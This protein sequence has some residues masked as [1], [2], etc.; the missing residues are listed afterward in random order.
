MKKYGIWLLFLMITGTVW[1]E[2]GKAIEPRTDAVAWWN[3]TDVKDEVGTDSMLKVV[4]NVQLNIPLA[5]TEVDASHARSGDGKVAI[6]QDGAYLNAEQGV[7][8]ELS[9]ETREMSFY[10]RVKLPEDLTNCPIFS[11]RGKD[12]EFA[13]NL[14][15][16]RDYIGFEMDT[17]QNKNRLALKAPFSDMRNPEKALTEWHDIIVRVN[18]AKVELYVDGRCYDEDFILGD[19]VRNHMPTLI[20][21]QVTNCDKVEGG[22]IDARFHGI[23]DTVA[24]WHRALTETEIRELSGGDD[25]D[26][27]NR[28]ELRDGEC[29]QYWTPPNNYFVGDTFPFTHNGVFHACF[30]VDKNHHGAK[31]GFGAHQWIQATSTDLKNWTFQPYLVPIEYQKEG[32]ICTGSLFFH[33]GT[34]Y[35]FYANRWS[36]GFSENVTDF[37]D[38]G[39]LTYSE[40]QDGIHFTKTLKPQFAQTPGY[41]NGT[42]DPIVFKSEKDGRFHMYATDHYR[43]KGCWLHASSAD[44]KTWQLEDPVYTFRAKAPECPDWFEWGG[45]YYVIANHY[46]GFYRVSDSPTGPWDLPL[47]P[48][49]LMLGDCRVPKTTAWKDGRRIITGFVSFG[50]YAG[51]L[52]FH[53]LIRHEDGSLGEKFVPEMIPETDAP[54]VE[55]KPFFATEKTWANVPGNCRITVELAFDPAR[56][57]AILDWSLQ[58]AENA[59][60][61]VSPTDRAVYLG[62]FKLEHVNFKTG[63]IVLDIFVKDRVLD[64]CVNDERTVTLHVEAV[65]ERTLTLKDNSQAQ[66]IVPLGEISFW[67]DAEIP[68]AFE[69]KLFRICPLK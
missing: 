6:F 8:G 5:G 29:L 66:H 26:K 54:V 9:V 24:I 21:A 23:I 37:P 27:R 48:N 25:A 22:T 45:T 46:N 17:T 61:R 19:L 55:E 11:K 51:A 40:S 31:N 2:T 53:E 36:K 68:T 43:G 28:L 3:M 44:L 4:G 18:E 38:Y 52:I 1:A 60:L 49:V 69:V 13:F 42:R 67:G 59:V 7:N 57:D 39:L 65:A 35:A 63:K 30:L 34:Y 33:E 58:L 56:R 15:A 32:S 14:F 16:F 50:G 64:V 20:G 12:G 47:E 62:K 41:G 10:V